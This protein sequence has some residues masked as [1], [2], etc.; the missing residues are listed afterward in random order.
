M[1]IKNIKPPLA[2]IE[3]ADLT[4][5]E[6]DTS[7][8]GA[9]D[10]ADKSDIAVDANLSVAA[11]A[12]ISASHTQNTDTD[13][14]STFE[15][16]FLKK[17][18]VENDAMILVSG[19]TADGKYNGIVIAGIAGATLAFGNCVYLA[20]A[21][22]RWELAKADA[23]ATTKCLLGICVLA[24]ANDGDATTILLIGEVR[25]DTAFPSFTVAAPVFLDA[26]TAGDL[27][28]TAPSGSG[29]QVRCVGQSLD[30]NTLWFNP[31]PDW[32]EIV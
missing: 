7:T 10:I 14:D 16:T 25:A 21:D 1:S 31:S 2:D 4:T 17:I 30:A 29:N 19:L 18:L 27:T 23:E 5:H 15:A 8:H 20:F 26:A 11:Q 28:S 13:L 3:L 9:S 24:A 12:A 22:S 6:S 32:I